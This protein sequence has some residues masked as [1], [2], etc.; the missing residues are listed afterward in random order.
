MLVSFLEKGEM[1]NA[2]HYIQMR[3]TFHHALYE[4]R[5]KKKSS[6]NITM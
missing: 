3:N 6:F 5:L 4:K 2:A 1:I